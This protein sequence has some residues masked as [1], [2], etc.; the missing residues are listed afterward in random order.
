VLQKG[1]FETT[2]GVFRTVL[3]ILHSMTGVIQLLCLWKWLKYKWKSCLCAFFIGLLG[4]SVW[5]VVL[6]FM[7]PLCSTGAIRTVCYDKS[8]IFFPATYLALLKSL[9]KFRCILFHSTWRTSVMSSVQCEI[10]GNNV[11]DLYQSY[12][13]LWQAADIA[14]KL[15]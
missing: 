9:N 15:L 10:L 13:I 5:Y 11:I 2:N 6:L 3:K 4:T 8:K 14:H 7:G 12:S 1:C